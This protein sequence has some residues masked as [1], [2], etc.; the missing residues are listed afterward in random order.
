MGFSTEQLIPFSAP[1]FRPFSAHLFRPSGA[2][3]GG[4]ASTAAGPRWQPQQKQI[5]EITSPVR[6]TTPASSCNLTKLRP[7]RFHHSRTQS[8]ILAHFF[9][10]SLNTT[11]PLGATI[12]TVLFSSP[13]L[14]ILCT[15]CINRFP[16]FR[17]GRLACSP[18]IKE[19]PKSRCFSR[20]TA[21]VPHLARQPAFYHSYTYL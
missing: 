2:A 14:C 12:L 18:I 9:P 13:P 17:A 15:S 3:S 7:Q 21:C 19:P 16:T 10:G 1:L 8:C 5:S 4:I 11:Q 20:V 6:F